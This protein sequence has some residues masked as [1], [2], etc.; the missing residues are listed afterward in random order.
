M[1]PISELK[2]HNMIR[3]L[4]VNKHGYFEFGYYKDG[5]IQIDGDWYNPD[6]FAGWMSI[7]DLKHITGVS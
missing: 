1:K 7:S 2:K 5:M 6:V 3:I 4:L